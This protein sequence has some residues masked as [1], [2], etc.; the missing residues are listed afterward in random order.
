MELAILNEL[1]SNVGF[2]IAICVAL[3][4]QNRETVKHYER[5]ILKFEQSIDKNTEVM[6]MLISTVRKDL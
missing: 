4:W 2:P 3:F 1:I 6:N 5:V